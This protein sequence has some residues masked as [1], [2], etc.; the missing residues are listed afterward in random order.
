[1]LDLST[2]PGELTQTHDNVAVDELTVAE[3][4]LDSAPHPRAPCT[5]R[6]YFVTVGAMH[7]LIKKIRIVFRKKVPTRNS[8]KTEEKY[9]YYGRIQKTKKY[10]IGHKVVVAA[11]SVTSALEVIFMR[12]AL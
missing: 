11:T 12:C 7:K 10:K 8:E 1:M 2:S 9:A 4:M 5:D 6:D 3:R